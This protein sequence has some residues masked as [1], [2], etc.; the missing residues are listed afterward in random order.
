MKTDDRIMTERAAREVEHGRMLARGD[1]EEIWGWA[2]P[3]GQVRFKRRAAAIVREADLRAG[4]RALELGCGTGQ[5]TVEF[6]RSGAEVTAVEISPELLDQARTRP[7]GAAVHWTLGRFESTPLDGPFDAVIGSSVLH[8]LAIAPSLARIR[9]LLIPGGTLC[10]AEP[11]FMNPQVFLERTFRFLPPFRSYVS[12]DETAFA[13]F[14]FA[15]RL[16]DA[17]FVDVRI[18]PFDWVH[19]SIPAALV[20]AITAAGGLLERLPIVREC[21]GS[22]LIRGRRPRTS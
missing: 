1:A 13:R 16:V 20:P 6:A 22:L 8:H 10:F 2:S 3:A 12:P 11:N 4:R 9:E 21:A 14:G 17:G 15:R 5:F 19:P 18:V 7:G